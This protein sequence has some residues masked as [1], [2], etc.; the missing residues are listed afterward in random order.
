V[1]IVLKGQ[2]VSK[3]EG[4]PP[5]S[6]SGAARSVSDPPQERVCDQAVPRVA[7]GDCEYYQRRHDNFLRRHQGCPHQ[8]PDYYLGYGEKYCVKFSTE[9][10]PKLSK[11]GQGWLTRARQNLQDAIEDGL[12]LDPTIELNGRAFREFAFGT[13]AD[14]YWNA[15]LHRLPLGD[16][17]KIVNEPDKKEW[18]KLDTWKQAGDVGG[19]E[20]KA[21]GGDAWDGAKH[22][23]QDVKQYFED[24]FH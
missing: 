6:V 7:T 14:A 4:S 2:Q 1:G 17:L 19:R 10:Y 9:L 8:V 16:K 24:L 20:V 18:L 12:Q 3:V 21:T 13:H 15:G 22:V 5:A 11:E 23:A